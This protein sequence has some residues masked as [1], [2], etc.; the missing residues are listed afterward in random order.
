MKEILIKNRDNTY[1]GLVSN[2]NIDELNNNLLHLKEELKE[3]EI[4]LQKQLNSNSSEYC[5][6]I[7]KFL[8]DKMKIYKQFSYDRRRLW[9]MLRNNVNELDKNKPMLDKWDAYEYCYMLSQLDYDLVIKY[10]KT[11]WDHLFDCTT[12]R[13]D[14]RIY[15]WLKNETKITSKLIWAEFIKGIKVYL[16]RKET[17]FMPDEVLYKKYDEILAKTLLLA[18][19]IKENGKLS[20]KNR[21][22]YFEKSIVVN[23]DNSEELKNILKEIRNN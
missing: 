18:S 10:D 1:D 20:S 13:Q 2:E 11:Y 7:G 3:Y 19:D 6:K 4:E 14:E 12:V 8:S 16:K 17:K 15:T 9:E 22:T 5:Y 23:K 21:D